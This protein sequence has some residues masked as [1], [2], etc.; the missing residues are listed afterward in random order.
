MPAENSSITISF[1]ISS[2]EEAHENIRVVNR[3]NHFVEESFN[4]FVGYKYKPIRKIIYRV[5][6]KKNN[7][8]YF[9][10]LWRSDGNKTA[11]HFHILADVIMTLINTLRE[12]KHYD[13][14]RY[15]YHVNCSQII[16]SLQIGVKLVNGHG[17]ITTKQ[18]LELF[19]TRYNVSHDTKTSRIEL[20]EDDTIRIITGCCN[21]IY[22]VP[23]I[24]C[25][26]NTCNINGLK[27]VF[28]TSLYENKIQQE[29]I[30][31]KKIN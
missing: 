9:K 8:Y 22:M 15:T 18:V 25:I 11:Y 17:K 13:S 12:I 29:E 20:V 16:P 2:R 7:C 1:I 6:Q 3:L 27:A 4:Y 26:A 21:I 30:N 19:S 10:V 23:F 31:C 24:F 28:N 5:S 14:I